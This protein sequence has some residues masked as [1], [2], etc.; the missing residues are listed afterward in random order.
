[1]LSPSKHTSDFAV[2]VSNCI[3]MNRT[4]INLARPEAIFRIATLPKNGKS[5]NLSKP[6]YCLLRYAIGQLNATSKKITDLQN[7]V[8]GYR[9]ISH[10]NR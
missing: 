5:L 2:G 6:Q 9:Q 1:M 8:I 10:M 3:A 4:M 7:N